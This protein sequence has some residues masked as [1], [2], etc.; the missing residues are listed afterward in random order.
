M[1]YLS[2]NDFLDTADIPW[3]ANCGSKPN[4]GLDGVLI[5][6]HDEAIAS[7]KSIDYE[8]FQ[9]DRQ[10]D[11]TVF[12]SSHHRDRNG[13]WNDQNAMIKENL[14]Q[15]FQAIADAAAAKGLPQVVVDSVKWDI[16][17]YY[18]EKAYH[19]LSIPIYFTKIMPIYRVGNI[20]CGYEGDYPNGKICIH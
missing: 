19:D 20:P 9:L 2:E 8:N 14:E 13:L 5:A 7:I 15:Q 17:D 18:Q 12:L 11:L 6:D 4:E 10:G 16:V 1:A 3:F